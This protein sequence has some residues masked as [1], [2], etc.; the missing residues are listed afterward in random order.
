LSTPPS[1]VS[2]TR[3]VA[4]NSFWFGL[5]VLFGIIGA[6]FTSVLVARAFGPER[7]GPFSLLQVLTSMTATLGSVGLPMTTR[8]YM[9]EYL[10]RGEADVAHAIYRACMKM[11]LSMSA[12]VILVAGLLAYVYVIKE[13]PGYFFISVI[14]VANMAPRMVGFIAAQANSAAEMM[15]RNTHPTLVG[16]M[17]N[18]GLTFFS[19]W[20]GWGLAGVAA[21]FAL[22]T[23]VEVALK[24]WGV[25]QWLKPTPRGTLSP[26]LKKRMFSFSG[27]GLVLLFLHIVVWDRS[28]M[29][30]LPV[31]NHD[32]RQLAFFS[33]AFNITE[34]LLTVPRAFGYALSSTMMAQFGRGPGRLRELTVAGAKY[35]MLIGLPLLGGLA[36]VATP[37]VR[38]YGESF[39]PMIPV[40]A[41]AALFAIPKA[42]VSPANSLL[43]TTER[44]RLMIWVGCTSGALHLG[45]N[46]LLTGPYGAVGAALA[47]GAAQLVAVVATWYVVSRAYRLDLR[48][49]EFGRIAVSGTAMAAVVVLLNRLLPGYAG[50]AVSVVVGAVIWFVMLRVTGALNKT[51]GERLQLLGKALPQRFRP[52]YRRLVAFMAA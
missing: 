28:A 38:L 31:M 41:L 48:L 8:K 47:S 51:D 22:G 10:N 6:F 26:E 11:Q 30:I 34:K 12:G 44:Q 4:L 32:V 21:A 42:L 13:Q 5:E 33:T 25:Y 46:F 37:V 24:L 17:I 15:K 1:A 27:E 50:L 20:I 29:L 2:N 36:C 45:L 52:V 9:A 39:A 49:G 3:T 40:L 19:L 14:M 35:S 23:I 7:L 18:V 16:L 43:Q